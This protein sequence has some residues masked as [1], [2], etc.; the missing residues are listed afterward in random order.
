[1]TLIDPS[2]SINVDIP[3]GSVTHITYENE[4]FEVKLIGDTSFYNKLEA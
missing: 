3:N 2:I 1:M 4:K